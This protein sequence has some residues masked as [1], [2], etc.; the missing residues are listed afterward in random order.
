ML[1]SITNP[2]CAAP[3]AKIRF[4]IKTFKGLDHE[5]EFK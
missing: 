2:L 3:A 1:I 4:L 5:I